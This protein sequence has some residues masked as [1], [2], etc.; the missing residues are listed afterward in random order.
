MLD[1]RNQLETLINKEIV[2]I[3]KITNS[4]QENLLK[5]LIEEHHHPESLVRNAQDQ[6]LVT[7]VLKMLRKGEFKRRQAP[8]L[9]KV[10]HQAFGS[11]WRLPIAAK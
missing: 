9:L 8:P 5:A 4:N 2:E 3:H 11:G 7:Q 1:E 6:K 10:S